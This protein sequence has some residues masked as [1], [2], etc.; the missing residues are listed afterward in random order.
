LIGSAE[1]LRTHECQWF[2]HA[3]D[4]ELDRITDVPTCCVDA[5]TVDWACGEREGL[6]NDLPVNDLGGLLA[7]RQSACYVLPLKLKFKGEWESRHR[8]ALPPTVPQ[9][10]GVLNSERHDCKARR[11]S[12]E[13]NVDIGC[14]RVIGRAYDSDRRDYH[15]VI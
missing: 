13:W 14:E 5:M 12:R 15:S 3:F 6:T 8:G 10:I 9:G 7:D 11:A 4:G 2:L 1:S